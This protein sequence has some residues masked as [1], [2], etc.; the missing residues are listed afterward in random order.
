MKTESMCGKAGKSRLL[1][2]WLFKP[3]KGRKGFGVFDENGDMLATHE[4][5]EVLEKWYRGM[6]IERLTK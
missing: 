3:G 1:N 5:S 4:K 2:D 6:R